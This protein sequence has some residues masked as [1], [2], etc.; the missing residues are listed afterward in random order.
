MSTGKMRL[1][2][3]NYANKKADYTIT[4][5]QTCLNTDAIQDPLYP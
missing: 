5:N 2:E 3:N 4:I 1:R